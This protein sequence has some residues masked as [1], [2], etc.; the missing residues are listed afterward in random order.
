MYK[1]YKAGFTLIELM[2]TIAI[3]GILAAI[4]IPSYVEYVNRGRRTE[5]KTAL[6]TN[7]H[8]LERF[9]GDNNT[10]VGAAL[11]ITQTPEQGTA[12][13]NLALAAT[14]TTFTLTATRTG[15]MATDRCGNFTLTQTGLR[16]LVGNS[17]GFDIERC[18]GR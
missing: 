4:A 11:P 5:A 1:K 16:G 7:A 12:A 9:R 2:I 15:V 18:W 8:W 17:A 3:I 10:Y 13:Y 14:A 6:M